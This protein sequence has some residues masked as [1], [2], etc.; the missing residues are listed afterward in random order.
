MVET[1]SEWDIETESDI[2][3]FIPAFVK[4]STER[5]LTVRDYSVPRLVMPRETDGGSTGYKMLY[6]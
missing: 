5:S 3:P 2:L 6:A 4:R 1:V